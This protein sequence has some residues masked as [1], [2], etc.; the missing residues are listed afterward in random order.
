MLI[1]QVLAFLAKRPGTRTLSLLVLPTY[2]LGQA[3]LTEGILQDA[4][5]RLDSQATHTSTPAHTMS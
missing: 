3:L 4:L 2:Y 1:S 5:T